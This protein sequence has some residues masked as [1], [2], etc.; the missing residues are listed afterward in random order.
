MALLSSQAQPATGLGI[1]RGNAK[2]PA[3]P[4]AQFNLRLGVALLGSE[5]EPFHGF[6]IVL[7]DTLAVVIHE[8]K[9]VLLLGITLL[10]GLPARVEIVLCREHHDGEQHR[11][12][13]GSSYADQPWCFIYRL[14]M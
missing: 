4:V 8:P 12:D 9:V 13:D 1:V 6:G 2:A 7:E 10:G 14:Q 3:V 11:H 5:P